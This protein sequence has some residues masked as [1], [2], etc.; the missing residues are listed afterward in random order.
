[1]KIGV[2]QLT[3][4]DDINEN[5]K[6]I[7]HVIESSQIEKPEI[8]FF[9]ENSLFFRIKSTES[10]KALKLASPEI[11][12]LKKLSERYKTAFH[13]TTAIED[14]GHV[15]NASILID[16]ANEVQILYRKLHLFDIALQG[17]KPIRESDTFKHGAKPHIFE[18]GGFKIGSSICYD[19]RFAELY[20]Y[21]AKNQVDIILIPAAFL[22]KTGQAHWEVLLRA[23]AIE[24]QCY[25]VAAGQTGVHKSVRHGETR[26]T[27]GH[28]MVIDPWGNILQYKADEEGAVF[29]E[30]SKDEVSK[31]RTQIPM[32]SHRRDVF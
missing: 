8:L 19:I 9:P 3:S 22:V 28:S 10:V 25:V 27:F 18:F 16:G 4:T 26:E 21:Y 23:R 15:F 17:Q 7:K 6:K 31:V 2:V 14:D 20:S 12:E 1:M 32:H 13:L 24:S 29:C 5:L 30:L 11:A